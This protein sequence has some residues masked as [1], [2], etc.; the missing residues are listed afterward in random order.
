MQ[1]GL[2][3]I[4]N[5]LTRYFVPIWFLTM[6][7][8]SSRA[9]CDEQVKPVHDGDKY[10]ASDTLA[11][12]EERNADAKECLG[13]LVW[14]P[15]NFTVR[16]DEAERGCGDFLVCFPSARPIGDRTIDEVSMEWF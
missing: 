14:T 15:T 1:R 2:H 8:I 5:I 11:C 4:A 10:S 12:G 6:C 16:L 13:T 7:L 3:V 9:F